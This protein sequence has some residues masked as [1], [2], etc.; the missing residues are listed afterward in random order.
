[1][2]HHFL[3]DHLE[4]K[5]EF[6]FVAALVL[7]AA[8]DVLFRLEELVQADPDRLKAV[9]LGNVLANHGCLAPGAFNLDHGTRLLVLEDVAPCTHDLAVRPRL[10]SDP[11]QFLTVYAVVSQSVRLFKLHVTQ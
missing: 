4:D 5:L 1:M 9:M 8:L 2:G 3:F 6:L 7:E 11:F 10:A